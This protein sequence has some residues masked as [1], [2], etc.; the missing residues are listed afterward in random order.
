MGFNANQA[1]VALV[2]E[3]FRDGLAKQG[4]LTAQ[5]IEQ[6]CLSRGHVCWFMLILTMGLF[7]GVV[8][9]KQ[10]AAG[11]AG[12]PS[13]KDASTSG[14]QTMQAASSTVPKVC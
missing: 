4:K 5:Q 11:T 2:I 12:T 1:A 8:Q 14:Q 7:V 9:L 6:V 10:F 13:N 3:A